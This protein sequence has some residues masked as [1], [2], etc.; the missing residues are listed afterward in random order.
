MTVEEFERIP[1][2]DRILE[3]NDGVL[4]EMP[5]QPAGH[6]IAK[7]DL[8]VLL[9]KAIEGED[10]MVAPSCTTRIGETTIRVPD[11]ARWRRSDI[12]KMNPERTMARTPLLIAEVIS[13]ETAADLQERIDQYFANGTPEVWTVNWESQT[14]QILTPLG[15]RQR[16]TENMIL[17]APELSRPRLLTRSKPNI[18]PP[19]QIARLRPSEPTTLPFETMHELSSLCILFVAKTIAETFLH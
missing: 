9:I 6:E 16:L 11:I 14:V 3:L 18:P 12:V 10:L 7:S 5:P 15:C 13:H 2:E 8:A 1:E 17:R 4:L 19:R